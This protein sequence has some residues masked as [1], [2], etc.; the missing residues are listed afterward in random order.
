M[1][2][3]TRATASVRA[4]NARHSRVV[5]DST[6][7]EVASVDTLSD[8]VHQTRG[9]LSKLIQKVCPQGLKSQLQKAYELSTGENDMV[10]SIVATKRDFYAAGFDVTFATH[11]GKMQPKVKAR[12]DSVV[13]RGRLGAN[14]DKPEPGI[15][16]PLGQ[17]ASEL[18][19]DWSATD[20]TI[21][22]WKVDRSKLVYVT[23][24]AP[25]TTR[26]DLS[27]GYEHL[28]V[29]IP[30]AVAVAIRAAT[31]RTGAKKT[32]LKAFPDKYVEAVRKGEKSVE[33][34]NEDGEF[35][36]VRTQG[37][38][39]DGLCAPTMR[40]VFLDIVLR[41]L[42]IS[43]DWS[44]AYGIKRLIELVRIG[45]AIPAGNH[46]DLRE[47]YPT[48][49][50]IDAVKAQFASA[51]GDCFRLYGDHTL[52]IKHVFPDPKVFDPTKYV[53][54]EERI[55]RWGGIPDVILT[56]KGDG[57][58]QGALGARRFVAAGKMARSTVG[59]MIVEFLAHPSMEDV[60]GMPGGTTVTAIWDEQN[61]KDPAQ[62]LKELQTLWDRGTLSNETLL[63]TTGHDADKEKQRKE[64]EA[65]EVK[66]WR[67]TFEPSQGLLLG[68]N[69]PTT[70]RPQ[71]KETVTEQPPKPSTDGGE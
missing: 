20:N 68:Q 49:K 71:T 34:K 15:T 16:H 45:S 67:P 62:V 21:L 2:G 14:P 42:I 18:I 3:R 43:G 41:D 29:D 24:L 38:T 32:E 36:I 47:L 1:A 9:S 30:D 8:I 61:L 63:E 35:W 48:Q 4:R 57:Y 26:Y 23:T 7:I 13:N 46:P 55:G 59:G 65:K 50:D 53:K 56:G 64:Q 19:F 52:D 27:T 11:S 25:H 10:S 37:K 12:C 28:W 51:L 69:N 54:V 17:V 33:L 70:G 22:H 66:I 40:G 39:F 31:Y 6:A 58:S 44:L 5:V 60:L